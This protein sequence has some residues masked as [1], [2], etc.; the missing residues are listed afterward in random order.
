VS[1]RYLLFGLFLTATAAASSAERFALKVELT[2]GEKLIE[3]GNSIVTRKAYT[4]SKGLKRSYLRLR[5]DQQVPGKQK[6]LYS[7]VDHFAGLLVTHQL[8]GN[9]VELTVVRNLVQPCLTEIRALAMTECKE[10]SPVV[11]TTTLSY[12]FPAEDGITETRPFG[13]DMTFRSTLQSVDGIR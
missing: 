9:T 3:R 7:T 8:T 11:T 6:K 1:M 10:L 4:W 12:S 5:C 13:E 2:Q